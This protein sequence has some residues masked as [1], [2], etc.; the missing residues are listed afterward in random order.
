MIA[1]RLGLASGALGRV[2]EQKGKE[3]AGATVTR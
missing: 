2:E 1:W 3:S